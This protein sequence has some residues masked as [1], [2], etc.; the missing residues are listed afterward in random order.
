MPD[1][2]AQ[3]VKI[4]GPLFAFRNILSIIKDLLMIIV[5]LVILWQI[6]VLVPKLSAG[7][8]TMGNLQD[9]MNSQN[10]G[11]NNL[12]NNKQDL[13]NNN[14]GSNQGNGS[15]NN[16][17]NSN[18]DYL[19]SVAEQMYAN[20]EQDKWDDAMGQLKILQGFSSQMTSQQ[21]QYIQAIEQALK[22]HDKESFSVSF[23]KL[24]KS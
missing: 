22:N 14:F 13:G 24:S 20:V 17:Q 11:N 8:E 12:Q 6:L 7:L 19:R 23:E 9:L 18:Q 3:P 10:S 21:Q 2:E 5:L 15:Q 1:L 16:N 4:K